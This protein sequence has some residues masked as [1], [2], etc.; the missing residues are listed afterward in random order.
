[1][2]IKYDSSDPRLALAS[3][4]TRWRAK[5]RGWFCPEYHRRNIQ[6]S[7]GP[8]NWKHIRISAYSGALAALHRFGLE[9][10]QIAPWELSDLANEGIVRLYEL[11]AHPKFHCWEWAA[12]VAE[13]AA[14]DFLKHHMFQPMKYMAKEEENGRICKYN[15]V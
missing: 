6:I 9:A 8:I 13:N 5:K 12:R 1:M 4:T 15:R 2:R 11:S 3:R 10:H 7:D 14:S